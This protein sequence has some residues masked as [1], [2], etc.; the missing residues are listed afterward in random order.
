MLARFPVLWS[1]ELDYVDG[2]IVS[3]LRNNSAWHQRF[4]LFTSGPAQVRITSAKDPAYTPSAGEDS[5]LREE[6]Q[7]G[8]LPLLLAHVRAQQRP[9]ALG[10]RGGDAVRSAGAPGARYVL[11]KIGVAPNNESAW[12]YLRG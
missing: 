8:R 3:D 12:N 5:R 11:S 7:Y 6:S 4:M 1:S 10:S 2:M 9:A